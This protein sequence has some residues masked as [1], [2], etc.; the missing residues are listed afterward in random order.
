MVDPVLEPAEEEAEEEAGSLWKVLEADLFDLH[1]SENNYPEPG[2][3]DPQDLGPSE[4]HRWVQK[5]LS[6]AGIEV[7]CLTMGNIH[8]G[9]TIVTQIVSDEFYADAMKWHEEG[10]PHHATDENNFVGVQVKLRHE[11]TW[12]VKFTD[13][14]PP[15]AKKRER[16]GQRRQS[17]SSQD[18]YNE[19]SSDHTYEIIV[20]FGT[21]LLFACAARPE[22]I[23]INVLFKGW[24]QEGDERV[25]QVGQR[26]IDVTYVN[27][28]LNHSQ[29]MRGV[30]RSVLFCSVLLRL[31]TENMLVC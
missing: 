7:R 11:H 20:P 29:V 15:P 22:T 4:W 5:V 16:G 30:L 12:L 6:T 14:L 19:V 31:S 21:G 3:Y 18:V 17:R 27:K 8:E 9:A 28:H 13:A 10:E 1:R 2:I 24:T 26:R 25:P 23:T